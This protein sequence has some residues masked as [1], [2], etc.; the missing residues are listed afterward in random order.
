[1][2]VAM[3][4]IIVTCMQTA[5]TLLVLITVPVRKDTLEMDAHVQVH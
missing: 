1:M 4:A 2:N 5:A 3:A